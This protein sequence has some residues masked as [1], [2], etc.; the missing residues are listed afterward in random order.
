M[1]GVIAG[2]AWRDPWWKLR[3]RLLSSA[4]FRRWAAEGRAFLSS[5]SMR[6]AKEYL[7]YR[8][9]TRELGDLHGVVARASA[10]CRSSA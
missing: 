7:P 8:I 4:A 2:A 5:S 3:D 6:Y 9:S 10:R 1:P